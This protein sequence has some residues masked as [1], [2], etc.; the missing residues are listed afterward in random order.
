MNYIIRLHVFVFLFSLSFCLPNESP[1]N[2]YG[3]H[4]L[5][6]IRFGPSNIFWNSLTNN[7]SVN[8]SSE[9]GQ[10][11]SEVSRA[12]K[13]GRQWAYQRNDKNNVIT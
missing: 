2:K 11:L 1:I 4:I 3:D 9:C 13:E 6:F 7:I 10:S 12:L 5:E 8:P